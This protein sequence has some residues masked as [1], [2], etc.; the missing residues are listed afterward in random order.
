MLLSLG[1]GPLALALGG[2]IA[3]SLLRGPRWGGRLDTEGIQEQ[4]HQLFSNTPK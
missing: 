2:G 3:L 4:A 1:G